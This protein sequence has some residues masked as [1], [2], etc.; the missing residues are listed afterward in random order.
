[1]KFR[2]KWDRRINLRVWLLKI[3]NGCV[4]KKLKFHYN[5]LQFPVPRFHNTFSFQIIKR[6]END[7]NESLSGYIFF[8]SSHQILHT[9][10]FHISGVPLKTIL[11]TM[12]LYIRITCTV[13]TSNKTT[14]RHTVKPNVFTYFL[15]G[16]SSIK[17]CTKWPWKSAIPNIST[18]KINK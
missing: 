4:R 7:K 17:K 3:G 16:R 18:D 13:K 5:S 14:H 12:S 10:V 15:S 1:M 9:I 6:D 8:K 11:Q 2:I